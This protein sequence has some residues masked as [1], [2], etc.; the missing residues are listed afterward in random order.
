M[1]RNTR[2][3][4]LMLSKVW[5]LLVKHSLQKI[6]IDGANPSFTKSLKIQ[7][8]E[9]LTTRTYQKSTNGL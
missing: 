4:T 9:G 2:D 7:G 5:D 6:Y 1:Q 3:L 8:V